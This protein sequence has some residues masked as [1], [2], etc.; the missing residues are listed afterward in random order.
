MLTLIESV[1]DNK[2]RRVLVKK[3]ALEGKTVRYIGVYACHLG[4]ESDD[5]IYIFDEC[6]ETLYV[7]NREIKTPTWALALCTPV[8]KKEGE[9]EGGK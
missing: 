7:N 5:V 3:N 4:A 6:Y 9:G 2:K 8:K 1:V